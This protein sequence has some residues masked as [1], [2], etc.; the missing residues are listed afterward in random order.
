VR[1]LAIRA[2]ELGK[3][4]S[5]GDRASAASTLREAVAAF[6]RQP[7]PRAHESDTSS[8]REM[9]WALRNIEFEISAGEIVAFIGPNGSGK[10][11]LLKI[12]SGI[13]EPSTGR[14][15]IYGRLS[16][17]L[18]VGTG[19]HPELTGRENVFLNGAILGMSRLEIK[20]KFDAIVDFSGVE[21]FIDIPVKRYSTGM[22]VRLAFSIAAHL[23]PDILV[24]DEVLAVGDAAFQGKSVQKMTEAM[25]AGTTVLFVSH[26]MSVVA[27][28]CTR[29][30]YLQEGMLRFDGS[31]A[32]AIEAYLG[33][34][35]TG[36]TE[37]NRA[38][39]ARPNLAAWISRVNLHYPE[40][41]HARFDTETDVTVD[42]EIQD[43]GTVIEVAVR[44]TNAWGVIVFSSRNSDSGGETAKQLTCGK[45]RGICT[46]PA[47]LLPPGRYFLSAAIL[48]PGEATFES[49]E[50]VIS[51]EVSPVGYPFNVDRLGVV[52]PVLR[53]E[54]AKLQE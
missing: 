22:Q 13:T 49:H 36:T 30:I 25:R 4:Y 38:Q 23:E 19:F 40:S 15:E 10:S 3:A 53:W 34:S 7:R 6:L 44:V 31:A 41:G 27:R 39:G 17:L 2:K 28:L 54:V 46:L 26:N 33:S 18:E 12:L 47:G 52:S 32:G 48:A 35:A 11:T 21:Q 16:P 1:T 24:V 29:A 9:I 20:Q 43:P 51:F 45:Y 8:T 14:A 5:L 50:N 37:W 42:F